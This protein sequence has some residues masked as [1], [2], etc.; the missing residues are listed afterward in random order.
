MGFS[1]FKR[2]KTAPDFGLERGWQFYSR[3]NAIDVVGSIFRI[4]DDDVRFPV[5]RVDVGVDS[6][7]EP[8]V[9][10]TTR[11]E[12]TVGILARFLDLVH[13]SASAAVDKVRTLEYVLQQPERTSTTDVAIDAAMESFLAG[14]AGKKDN[15]YYVVRQTRSA[16][17]MTFRL[18]EQLMTDLRSSCSKSCPTIGLGCSKC[19]V[20]WIAGPNSRPIPV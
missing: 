18:T 12:I 15:R 10:I 7:K 20:T 13:L 8:G 11:A 16:M 6:T 5:H 2:R 14:F 17:S 4:D 1:I 9:S 3:P 19:C